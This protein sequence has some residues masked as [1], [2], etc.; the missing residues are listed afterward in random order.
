MLSDQE[1]SFDFDRNLTS[2][3]W[4]HVRRDQ[5]TLHT[6]DVMQ[7]QLIEFPKRK[8]RHRV[9]R[10]LS[11]NGTQIDIPLSDRVIGSLCRPTEGEVQQQSEIQI[12]LFE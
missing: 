5:L 7:V 4:D 3:F 8:V 2:Q 10:V 6:T 9:I 11:Y 12:D 1:R